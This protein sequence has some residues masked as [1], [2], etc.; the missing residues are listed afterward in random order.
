M[1]VLFSLPSYVVVEI[2]LHTSQHN[3]GMFR[4]KRSD[5]KKSK[6]HVDVWTK[7]VTW[8]WH[9]AAKS[10]KTCTNYCVI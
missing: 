5:W 6:Y 3:K 7:V 2:R 1:K 8:Q 10:F 4:A 9:L